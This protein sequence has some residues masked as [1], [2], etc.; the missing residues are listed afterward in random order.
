VDKR[1][2]AE[3]EDARFEVTVLPDPTTFDFKV[4]SKPLDLHHQRLESGEYEITGTVGLNV[5]T[6]SGV[7]GRASLALLVWEDATPVDEVIVSL[8]ISDGVNS[9][10]SCEAPSIEP[11]VDSSVATASEE[12]APRASLH[13][14]ELPGRGMMGVFRGRGQKPIGWS[15]GSSADELADKLNRTILPA[16]TSAVEDETDEPLWMAGRS[17]FNVIFPP[18]D[19][20][21]RRRV[22]EFVRATAPAPGEAAPR[23]H[24]RA[25]NPRSESPILVPLGIAVLPAAKDAKEQQVIGDFLEVETPLAVHTR[26][27]SRCP[28]RWVVVAPDSADQELNAATSEKVFKPHWEGP[29]IQRFKKLEDF[30]KWADER[31]TQSSTAFLVVSH[32]HDGKLWFDPASPLDLAEIN[33]SYDAPSLLILNACGSAQSGGASAFSAMNAR[34]VNAGIATLTEV[35]GAM[36]GAFLQCLGDTIDAAPNQLS[37]G[38]AHFKSIACLR[39]KTSADGKPYGLRALTYVSLGDTQASICTPH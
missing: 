5:R 4:V 24:V 13:L 12:G 38:V 17:L 10:P 25:S 35:Q 23:I 1:V 18:K 30:R 15:L 14:V 3:A 2:L 21:I 9:S 27:P 33:S 28:D 11:S 37:L 36:A 7:T 29:K 31:E 39:N 16:L 26:L 22:T 20:E 34:G 8:C 19:V 6:R 32:H